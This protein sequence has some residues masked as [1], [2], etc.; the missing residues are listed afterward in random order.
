M[1]GKVSEKR[2]DGEAVK[3]SAGLTGKSK[4][5]ILRYTVSYVAGES[6]GV[7]E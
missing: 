3:R 7:P 2:S 5:P 1:S 4:S 6:L